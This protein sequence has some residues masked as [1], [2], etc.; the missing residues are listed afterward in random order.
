M[1]DLSTAA[2]RP[3][4]AHEGERQ[5]AS[6]AS[7]WTRSTHRLVVS[8]RRGDGGD[9]APVVFV[10]DPRQQHLAREGHAGEPRAVGADAA[11]L[12]VQL[13]T[14]GESAQSCS[15]KLLTGDGWSL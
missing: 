11:D 2:P 8:G 4:F 15:V 3:G 9:E 6:D 1:R 14:L 12:A 10:P 13:M 7:R 5:R